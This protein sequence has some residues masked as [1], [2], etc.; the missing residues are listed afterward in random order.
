MDTVRSPKM[1]VWWLRHTFPGLEPQVPDP[2]ALPNHRSSDL[3]S[4]LRDYFSIYRSRQRLGSRLEKKA[5]RV[6]PLFQDVI[7]MRRS[8]RTGRTIGRDGL[9]RIVD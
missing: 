3:W 4:M 6:N 9:K 7:C 5:W 8:V 1:C 2:M